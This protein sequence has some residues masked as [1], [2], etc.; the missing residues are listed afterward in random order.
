MLFASPFLPPKS[1][2]YRICP[3]QEIWLLPIS[4]SSGE[5][6]K[7]NTNE[8]MEPFYMVGNSSKNCRRKKN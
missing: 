3:A 8:Q 6:K 1:P 2:A 7:S 5:L 4:L